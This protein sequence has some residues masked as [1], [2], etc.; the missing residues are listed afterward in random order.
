M[1]LYLIIISTWTIRISDYCFWVLY[2]NPVS[3]IFKIWGS[4]QVRRTIV[5]LCTETCRLT[6]HPELNLHELLVEHLKTFLL[7]LKLLAQGQGTD[8]IQ[9]G[10]SHSALKFSQDSYKSCHSTQLAHWIQDS[11]LHFWNSFLASRMTTCSEES[12][13]GE[14]CFHPQSLKFCW[15]F[16]SLCF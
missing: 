13:T 10:I 4:L 3:I 2:L 6:I 15:Y 14:E 11:Y 9:G 12:L 16:N 8:W 1:T 5:T 7:L